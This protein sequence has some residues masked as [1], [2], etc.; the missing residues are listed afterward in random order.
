MSPERV[1]VSELGVAPPDDSDTDLEDALLHMSPLPTI[2]SPLR[3]PVEV[4]Q[5][6]PSL[7]PEPP[8]PAQPDP[9]PSVEL[10]DVPLREAD[11]RP[12]I[13]L[14]PSFFLFLPL[15]PTMIRPLPRSH[16]TC[17]MTLDTCRR[18]V[19]LLW[20]STLRRMLG[21]PSDLQLLSLPLLP[22]PVADVSDPV[23]VGTPSVGEPVLM[24][25][26]VPPDLS[27]EDPF[28]V[29]RTP[30]GSGD[31]PRVLENLPGCQ[32]QMT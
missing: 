6:Y 20:T 32:F 1:A 9:V 8:V 7:Y 28:D 26:V 25:A 22:V 24:P 23:L 17:R 14:F 2:V 18:I 13:D 21:D 10:Q 31:T 30:S 5:V 29:D 12:T 16:R 4:L 19:R 15:S 3:E 27:Q 11:E